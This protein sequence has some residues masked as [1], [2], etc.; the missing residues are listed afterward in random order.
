MSRWNHALAARQ[1]RAAERQQA[2][3]ERIQAGEGLKRAA[4]AVGIP[5]RT[6]CRYRAGAR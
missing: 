4:H 3:A 6:A 2:L 5:Y 1:H